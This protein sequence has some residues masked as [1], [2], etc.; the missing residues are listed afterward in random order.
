EW[1]NE[2]AIDGTRSNA[3]LETRRRERTTAHRNTRRWT[4]YPVAR[5]P[6]LAHGVE[7]WLKAADLAI[8]EDQCLE[9][10]LALSRVDGLNA[11]NESLEVSRRTEWP[12]NV[13]CHAGAQSTSFADVQRL[14][15]RVPQDVH[16]GLVWQR[17][18]G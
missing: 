7:A 15:R 16:P 14:L 13:G 4:S 12:M 9:V 1:S 2:L 10:G 17:A 5:R 6:L 18:G 11:P 3:E 8:L